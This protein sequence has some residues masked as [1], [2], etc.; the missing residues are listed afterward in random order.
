MLGITE[1]AGFG[2]GALE[3]VVL[4]MHMDGTN[5][6]TT[7]IDSTGK[8]SPT[9]I[10]NAQISTAQSKFGG[11]SA[12]F[13]GTGD[14]ISVPSSTNFDL[15]ADFTIEFFVRFNGTPAFA[16]FITRCNP[17]N[18]T[19]ISPIVL[20]Y[21]GTNL[22]FHA[23]SNYTS[24]N[25]LSAAGTKTFSGNTWYHIAATR[26]GNTWKTFVDGQTDINSTAS[27][28]PITSSYPLLIGSADSLSSRYLYSL[29]GW[30]DELRITKGFARYT[31][32]FTPPT[33]PFSDY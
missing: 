26:Q 22:R 10:N 23:S 31:A 25:I 20:Y 13:D 5:G 8:N 12:V 19:T 9:A 16:E 33:A 17:G 3:N 21:N 27:G 1:L 28:T 14:A 32:D 2:S 15:D 11:S 29:N 24:W 30:I 7:F 6:S 18:D 4:A